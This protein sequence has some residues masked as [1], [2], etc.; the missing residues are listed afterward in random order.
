MAKRLKET[1]V[2][3]NCVEVRGM[4]GLLFWMVN[5]IDIILGRYEKSLPT[6]I[7]I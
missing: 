4:S 5:K 3:S 6:K 7:T 1:N 2:F